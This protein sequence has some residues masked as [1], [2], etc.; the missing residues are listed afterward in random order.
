MNKDPL[1]FAGGVLVT[2]GAML[3]SFRAIKLIGQWNDQRKQR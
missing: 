3:Y 2:I 1:I